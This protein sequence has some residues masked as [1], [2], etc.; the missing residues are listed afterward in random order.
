MYSL[1]KTSADNGNKSQR[2]SV[3]ERWSTWSEKYQTDIEEN[4]PSGVRGLGVCLGATVVEG[5]LYT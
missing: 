1:Y 2:I 3:I 4:I 5:A